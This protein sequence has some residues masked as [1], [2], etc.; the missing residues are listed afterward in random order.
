MLVL[1]R[2]PGQKILIGDEIE[3]TILD[4]RGEGIR[5]G[6]SAPR[7]VRIQREEV[8]RAVEAANREASHGDDGAQA[9]L[10]SDLPR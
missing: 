7:D 2:K 10:L 6:I 3:V 1:T 4:I 9:Q 8:V 5:V